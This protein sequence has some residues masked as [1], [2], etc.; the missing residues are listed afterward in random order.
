[1]SV[2]EEATAGSAEPTGPQAAERIDLFP[3][4]AADTGMTALDVVNGFADKPELKERYEEWEANNPGM[5][6]AK[7]LFGGI[8]QSVLTR[9]TNRSSIFVSDNR[10]QGARNVL[11]HLRRPLEKPEKTIDDF[12]ETHRKEAL[13]KAKVDRS[14]LGIPM[15]LQQILDGQNSDRRVQT[16]RHWTVVALMTITLIVASVALLVTI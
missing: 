9:G 5:Q 3:P 6:R 12:L 16:R 8:S 1:M 15:L 4:W 2:N 13:H 14:I 7:Q 11:G 10:L